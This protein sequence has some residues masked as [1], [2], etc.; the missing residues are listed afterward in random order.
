[1]VID[2]ASSHKFVISSDKDESYNDDDF[3]E[4]ISKSEESAEENKTYNHK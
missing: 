1:L 4:N 2:N 3:S